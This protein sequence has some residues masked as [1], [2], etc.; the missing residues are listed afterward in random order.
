MDEG[1]WCKLVSKF[2]RMCKGAAGTPERLAA[3]AT[4]R[5]IHWMHAAGNPLV[6][7]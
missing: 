4:R 6:A 5:G 7:I 2:G 1:T 3:E